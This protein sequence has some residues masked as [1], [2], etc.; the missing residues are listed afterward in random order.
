MKKE[1]DAFVGKKG[2]IVVIGGLMVDV[3]IKDVKQSYGKNRFLVSPIKGSGET[4]V[5]KVTLL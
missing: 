4:W 5:E 3:L 1:I 2:S